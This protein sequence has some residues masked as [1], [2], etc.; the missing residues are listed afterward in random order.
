MTGQVT[1]VGAGPG[2]PGLLTRRALAALRRADLVLHDA[3]VPAAVLD[4]ARR[5]KRFYVGK[6]CGRH[7]MSQDAINRLMIRQARKGLRVVRL[8]CGD[9]YVFGRGGEEVLALKAAG[10]PVDVVPG[11]STALAAP[12]LAGIPVTHRGL[13]S[14]LV[15]V[16]GHAEA[17]YRPVLESLPQAA[18]T[19]VVLMGMANRAAVAQ[20]LLEAGWAPSTP[21]AIVLGASHDGARLWTGR[22]DDLGEASI[23]PTGL[24]GTLV[25]G[26]VVGLA[27]RIGAAEPQ[28]ER[29]A[30]V[31][32]A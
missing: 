17:A 15:V 25:I 13:A 27:A 30:G 14:A 1:L 23:E 20:V 32:G 31:R 11:V 3:L 29:A 2:D 28:V 19:I 10:I 4:V 22:L 12:A 26:P 7:A 24:P 18:A 8:K 6:R 16:S 5:A 9:P 21:A